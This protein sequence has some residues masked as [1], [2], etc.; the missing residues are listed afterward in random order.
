MYISM[1][2]SRIIALRDKLTALGPQRV[3]REVRSPDGGLLH[4]GHGW[5]EDALPEDVAVDFTG[6]RVADL[7]CNLGHHSF[8][9]VRRG[10]SEVTGFDMDKDV[11]EAANELA[12]LYGLSEWVRFRAADLLIDP[13]RESFDLVLFVDIIG[14]GSITKGKA[15]NLL[16]AVAEMSSGEMLHT[17]R[18]VYTLDEL[19]TSKEELARHYPDRFIRDG[20]FHLLDYAKHIYGP[21]WTANVLSH[22]DDLDQRFK[23]PVF[24]TRT[25]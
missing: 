21:E 18:P 8:L 11:V 12:D 17:M 3:W 1:D 22:C 5:D 4:P 13:P 6:K 14:R 20:R 16:R 10:A 25:G 15:E 24:F 19:R 9:A 7:G 2:T 23:Y